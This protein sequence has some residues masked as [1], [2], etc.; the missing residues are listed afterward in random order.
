MPTP[1]KE[2]IELVAKNLKEFYD[3]LEAGNVSEMLVAQ[4]KL[5]ITVAK[6]LKD[7]KNPAIRAAMEKYIHRCS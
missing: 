6:S 3:C 4:R 2:F 5:Q 1:P 7:I